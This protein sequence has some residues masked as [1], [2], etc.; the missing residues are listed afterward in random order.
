MAAWIAVSGWLRWRLTR[1]G[2]ALARLFLRC[3]KGI[4]SVRGHGGP[5]GRIG[6]S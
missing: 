3:P 4:A 6:R 5:D 1:W 2:Q